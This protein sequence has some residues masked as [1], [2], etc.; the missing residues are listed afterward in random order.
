MTKFGATALPGATL[1]QGGTPIRGILGM[2]TLYNC[3]GII[4][5]ENMNLFLK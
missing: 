1:T 4:D 2:D 3:N 5:L